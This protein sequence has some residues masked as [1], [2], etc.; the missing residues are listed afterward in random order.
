[1][2]YR[3]FSRLCPE[4]STKLY[5]PEF[6]FSTTKTFA[7]V[8]KYTHTEQ[9]LKVFMRRKGISLSFIHAITPLIPYVFFRLNR[10]RIH[11][12]QNE[13][14]TIQSGAR[15]ITVTYKDHAFFC[16]C[17]HPTASTGKISTCSTET[18]S[19]DRIQVFDKNNW[20]LIK[21]KPL[22]GL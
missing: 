15:G 21:I 13:G 16:H 22:I 19:R 9:H 17:L 1:M 11:S 3:E 7:F 5:F 12:A 18:G 20:L 14:N 8:N 6:G 10:G 2:T 4:T